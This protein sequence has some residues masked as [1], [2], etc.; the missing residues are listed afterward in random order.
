MVLLFLTFAT[1]TECGPMAI[2]V[3]VWWKFKAKER[4]HQVVV[5]MSQQAWKS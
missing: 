1:K 4:L 5:V 3:R 2:A